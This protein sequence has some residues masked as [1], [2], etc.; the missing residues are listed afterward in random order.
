[1]SIESKFNHLKDLLDELRAGAYS[2][3][4]NPLSKN[5]DEIISSNPRITRKMVEDIFDSVNE[6]AEELD[7]KYFE[8][9]AEYFGEDSLLGEYTRFDSQDYQMECINDDPN[10]FDEGLAVA[11]ETAADKAHEIESELW[12]KAIDDVRYIFEKVY[13]YLFE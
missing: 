12:D 7:S 9:L 5:E 8:D 1:M 13:P 10:A 6:L 2:Y 3:E 11:Q 4:F